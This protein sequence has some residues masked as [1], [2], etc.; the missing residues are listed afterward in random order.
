MGIV[1]SLELFIRKNA[2]FGCYLRKVIHLDFCL[3]QGTL[4]KDEWE[5]AGL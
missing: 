3:L 1:H 4:S 2:A 5:A